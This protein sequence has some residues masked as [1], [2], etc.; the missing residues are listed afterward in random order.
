MTPPFAQPKSND[1][2]HLKPA[3]PAPFQG[4]VYVLPNPGLADTFTRTWWLSEV[5]GGLR[6]PFSPSKEGLHFALFRPL[7]LSVPVG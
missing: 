4:R 3:Q 5:A 2:S 1:P 6:L 7:F